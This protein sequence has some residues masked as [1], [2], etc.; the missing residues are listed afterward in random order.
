MRLSEAEAQ[1]QGP[2][3]V[4]IVDGP[5]HVTH[6]ACC[7][8]LRD[9]SIRRD[10]VNQLTCRSKSGNG[11]PHLLE[12]A[13]PFCGVGF[14]FIDPGKPLKTTNDFAILHTI[15]SDRLPIP[16]SFTKFQD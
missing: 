13:V 7:L 9:G 8:S 10:A 6:T 5:Q 14:T 16:A 4:Q 11:D 3:H 12:A 2:R 15:E 1:S